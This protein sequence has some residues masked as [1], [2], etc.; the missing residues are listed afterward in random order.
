MILDKMYELLMNDIR[1]KINQDM[2]EPLARH[3][4]QINEL[5]KLDTGNFGQYINDVQ[6]II[7]SFGNGLNN[8][9]EELQ[10]FKKEVYEE[11]DAIK[12]KPP[13]IGSEIPIATLDLN[14]RIRNSLLAEGLD[15]VEKVLRYHNE[16]WKKHG[17]L[18]LPDMGI[19]SY[20]ILKAELDKHGFSIKDC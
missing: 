15:T 11:L 14:T 12:L 5:S 1:Q 10:K 4:K 19:K 18:N 13:R 16:S 9:Y 8:V 2:A 17:L 3:Q 6:R 20:K 7:N